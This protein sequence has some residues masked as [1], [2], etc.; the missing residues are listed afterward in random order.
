MLFVTPV[1]PESFRTAS[2]G[3]SADIDKSLC[4]SGH[5]SLLHGHLNGVLRDHCVPLENV[6]RTSGNL[7]IGSLTEAPSFDPLGDRMNAFDPAGC[8]LGCHLLGVMG[9]VTC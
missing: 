3:R 2:S 5:P 8:T 9:H 6:G 4:P 1:T 7:L